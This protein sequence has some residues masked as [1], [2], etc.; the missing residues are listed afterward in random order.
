MLREVISESLIQLNV[1]AVDRDDAIRKAAEPL[2]K[3][4][5]IKLSYIDA[6]IKSINEAG[7]Y[8]VLLPHIALPHA[9][10]EDG[11]I[12]NA[13][14]ITTLKTPIEFGSS[15]NDPV[16]Y[17]FTL[18]AKNDGKHLDAL[19][20]LAEL[21]EDPKFLNM[22]DQ[23]TKPKEVMDYILMNINR[24]EDENVQSVSSL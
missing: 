10:P 5:K 4:N 22:V 16:K 21:F 14:G 9:R 24:K 23:A 11:A 17:L 20:T 2:L 19:A 6:I 8:F 15:N 13:I 1:D 3:E 18:S 7:P 12:E